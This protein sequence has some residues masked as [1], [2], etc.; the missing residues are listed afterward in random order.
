MEGDDAWCDGA[1]VGADHDDAA[2]ERGQLP[3]ICGRWR[4]R[5]AG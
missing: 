3:Q 1:A 2:V 5:R 4:K